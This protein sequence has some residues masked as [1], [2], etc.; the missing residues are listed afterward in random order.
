MT[1]REYFTPGYLVEDGAKPPS[2]LLAVDDARAALLEARGH[3]TKRTHHH[4]V[5]QA[6]EVT[7]HGKLVSVSDLRKDGAP[8]AE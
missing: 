2:V 3:A 4:A 7:S 1:E 8:S 6:V 5:C